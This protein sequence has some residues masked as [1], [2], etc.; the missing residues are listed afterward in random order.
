MIMRIDPEEVTEVASEEVEKDII[1]N[2]NLQ[3][4]KELLLFMMRNNK[5]L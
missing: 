3:E 1:R 5:D 2:L 4:M